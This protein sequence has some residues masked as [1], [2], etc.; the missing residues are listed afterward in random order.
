[1]VVPPLVW[2]AAAAVAAGRA[3]SGRRTW[4]GAAFVL[5]AGVAVTAVEQY[6]HRKRTFAKQVDQ[7]RAA[8]DLLRVAT[9]PLRGTTGPPCMRPPNWE[10]RN[11]RSPGGSWTW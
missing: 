1:M 7:A 11:S 2:V 10:A 8:N 4:R 3:H 6:Q 9:P 5:A